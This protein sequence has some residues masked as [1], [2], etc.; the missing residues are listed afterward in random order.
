MQGCPTPYGMMLTEPD[1]ARILKFFAAGTSCVDVSAMGTGRGLLGPSSR[2][3]AIWCS[4]VKHVRPVSWQILSPCLSRL[5]FLSQNVTERRYGSSQVAVTHE[6]TGRFL[7]AIFT[8][9][10]GKWYHVVSVPAPEKARSF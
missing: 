3:L 4:E 7:R 2:P 6:C 8:H 1:D 10:L 9:H 5:P